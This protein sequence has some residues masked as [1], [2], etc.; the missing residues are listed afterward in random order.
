MIAL[1]HFLE[2]VAT[3]LSWGLE[4]Y[5]WLIIARALISWVNPDPYNPIVRFL[6]NVTEPVLGALRRRFRL[7]YGGLDLSPLVVLAIILFL[8]VFL[9]Q[10]LRDYARMLG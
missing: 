8:K 4:I 5:M 9:V 10:T 2:A 3:V 1:R 7:F 6:F